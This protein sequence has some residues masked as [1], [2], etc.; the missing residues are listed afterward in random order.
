MSAADVARAVAQL[1]QVSG[2][3]GTRGEQHLALARATARGASGLP[4]SWGTR[5]AEAHVAYLTA[6]ATRHGGI[7]DAVHRIVADLRTLA[8]EGRST[9][10]RLQRLEAERYRLQAQRRTAELLAAVAGGATAGAAAVITVPVTRLI[11]QQRAIGRSITIEHQRWED[12]ARTVGRRITDAAALLRRAQATDRQQLIGLARA[13]AGTSGT[14]GAI[15]ARDEAWVRALASA[16]W[17]EPG[18]DRDDLV[19]MT[20]QAFAAPSSRRA[21]ALLEPSPAGLTDATIREFAQLLASLPAPIAG[22]V[23]TSLPDA[24]LTG[25]VATLEG[26][27]QQPGWSPVHRHELWIGIGRTLPLDAYRHL[28]TFTEDL[29]PPTEDVQTGGT[30]GAYAS[31]PGTLARRQPGDEHPFGPNDPYQGF[32]NNCTLIAGMIGVANVDPARLEDMFERNPNGTYTVTFADGSATIVST[33]VPAAT[34]YGR[35]AFVGLSYRGGATAGTF[36]YEHWPLLLEKAY[37]QRFGGW[38]ATVR[39]GMARSIEDMVGGESRSRWAWRIGLD[40]LT[41]A[42]DAGHVVTAGTSLG[43]LDG[44]FGVADRYAEGWLAP[45]HAY[46]VDHVDDAGMIHLINPWV[47]SDREGLRL[48]LREFRWAFK[49]VDINELP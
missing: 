24:A 32:L 20:A 21:R 25:L 26:E 17:A 44:R 16:L 30:I 40:D 7:A 5:D 49:Q 45:K 14:S 19:A 12:A 28:A 48:D 6:T 35:P 47:P 38:N 23:V 15:G 34:D 41:T 46:V 13:L 33:E 3:L 18:R 22:A 4:G 11:E 9:A 29:D 37:A 39:R 8:E 1:E 42:L 27:L 36:T 2:W 31:F 43:V 10:T